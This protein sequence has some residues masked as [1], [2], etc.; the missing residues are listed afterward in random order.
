MKKEVRLLRARGIESLMLSIE[1]FNRPNDAG[2][3]HGV[4]IF[5]DH[6]FEML[7]KAAILHRGGRIREPRAKQTIGFGASVRK[8]LSDSRLKF[9][10]ESQALVVQEEL[11]WIV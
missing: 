9:L 1:L 6:A 11:A 7:F 2:R 3:T 4:L 5:L 8:G 10:S